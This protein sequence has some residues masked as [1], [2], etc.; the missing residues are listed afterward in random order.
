MVPEAGDKVYV[1]NIEKGKYPG[2]L[3]DHVDKRGGY[4]DVGRVTDAMD[5]HYVSITNFGGMELRWEGFLEDLQDELKKELG[6]I[7]AGLT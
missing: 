2:A 5:C 4:A 6:G 1:P 7:Q 3:F